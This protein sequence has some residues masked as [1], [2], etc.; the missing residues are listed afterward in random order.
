M[1]VDPKTFRSNV[2]AL[3]PI[4]DE[5]DMLSRRRKELVGQAKLLKQAVIEQMQGLGKS[6]CNLRDGQLILKQTTRKKQTPKQDVIAAFT[7]VVGENVT[8][9]IVTSLDTKQ[10]QTVKIDLKRQ[11]HKGTDAAAPEL[12][13]VGSTA[14][15]EA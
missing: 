4:L 5:I 15:D 7:A 10:E 14:E 8:A 6:Q 13:A 9:D 11:K 1:A 12:S 3:V 2:K